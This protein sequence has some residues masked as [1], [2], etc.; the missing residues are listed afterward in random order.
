M[1]QSSADTAPT[2]TPEFKGEVILVLS[3]VQPPAAVSDAGNSILTS[4]TGHS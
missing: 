2:I 1:N 3:T 4:V